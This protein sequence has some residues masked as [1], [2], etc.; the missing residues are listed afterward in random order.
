V[1][2]SHREHG[3]EEDFVALLKKV[4]P[5]D[6]VG[7]RIELGRDARKRAGSYRKLGFQESGRTVMLSGVGEP[8]GPR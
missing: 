8:T 6:C 5:Q 7:I 2:P 3:I 4:A 1:T